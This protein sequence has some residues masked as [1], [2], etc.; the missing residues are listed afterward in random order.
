MTGH[1]PQWSVSSNATVAYFLFNLRMF[2]FSIG[3]TDIEARLELCGLLT[4]LTGPLR[5]LVI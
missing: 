5:G 3:L 4:G 1:T 2:M